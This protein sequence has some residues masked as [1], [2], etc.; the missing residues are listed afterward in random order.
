MVT[1]KGVLRIKDIDEAESGL[2]TCIGKKGRGRGRGIQGTVR[3]GGG[4]GD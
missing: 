2:S 3:K 4:G 1:R